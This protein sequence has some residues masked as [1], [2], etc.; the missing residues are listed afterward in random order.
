M[1]KV[2]QWHYLRSVR[3]RHK[4]RHI[5]EMKYVHMTHGNNASVLT[6][7]SRITSRI[8]DRTWNRRLFHSIVSN[9][10]KETVSLLTQDVSIQ[11]IVELTKWLERQVAS[12]L[13]VPKTTLKDRRHAKKVISWRGIS[14]PYHIYHPR[15]KKMHNNEN[16]SS[17]KKNGI[18]NRVIHSTQPITLLLSFLRNLCT[19]L[20]FFLWIQLVRLIIRLRFERY[21]FLLLPMKGLLWIINVC[22]DHRAR[23][24]MV[25]V[26]TMEVD[27]RLKLWI[28]SSPP[29]TIVAQWKMKT[30]PPFGGMM[31]EDSVRVATTLPSTNRRI[32]QQFIGKNKYQFGDISRN[33]LER[34]RV[35]DNNDPTRTAKDWMIQ[36]TKKYVQDVGNEIHLLDQY[37]LIAAKNTTVIKHD[38]LKRAKQVI[39]N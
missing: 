1:K 28:M 22:I 31:V 17:N 11:D 24:G 13:L 18:T 37:L 5:I 10:T 35:T 9:E 15:L 8:I 29:T 26:M 12:S 3:R 39:K 27:R 30:P 19:E 21:V 2:I 25:R 6:F 16:Q 14:I 38:I 32:I 34:L 33:V 20:F 7:I 23:P 36:K 4:E